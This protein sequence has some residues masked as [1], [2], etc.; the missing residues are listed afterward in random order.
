AASR[1]RYAQ[2]CRPWIGTKLSMSSPW[3]NGDCH[4]LFGADVQDA[5]L[6][7]ALVHAHHHALGIEADALALG[8]AVS[9]VHAAEHALVAARRLH[10]LAHLLL[11][12][13]A[14]AADRIGRE[15]HAVVAVA[16]HVVR[17]VAHLL[18]EA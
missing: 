16:H 4:H 18:G 17:L 10:R 13:A 8:E 9:R 11:V 1:Q 2:W 7:V 6:L 15:H 14:G 5:A 12:G 3:R